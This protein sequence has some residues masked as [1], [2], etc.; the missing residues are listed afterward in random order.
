M[1]VV[2]AMTMM[3]VDFCFADCDHVD[4]YSAFD[5]CFEAIMD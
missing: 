4:A 2:M 1:A 3:I 5:R